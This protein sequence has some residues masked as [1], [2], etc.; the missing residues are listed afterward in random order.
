M[1]D[2]EKEFGEAEEKAMTPYE[3]MLRTWTG[4]K[5][6]KENLPEQK[7]QIF[8]RGFPVPE[9]C[10]ICDSTQDWT[11]GVSDW[12]KKNPKLTHFECVHGAIVSGHRGVM[13]LDSRGVVRNQITR[14]EK[15]ND[16]KE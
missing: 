13:Q 7:F 16:I 6:D 3:K 11:A 2:W 15:T 4:G 8:Q 10:S 1:V 14:W 9:R 5:S 12:D